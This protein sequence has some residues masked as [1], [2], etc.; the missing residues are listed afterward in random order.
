MFQGNSQT[1]RAQQAEHISNDNYGDVS[2]PFSPGSP[3][4]YVPQ[5]PMEPA[6]SRSEDASRASPSEFKSEVAGWPTQPRLVPTKI[7]CEL[8]FLM[9]CTQVS[10]D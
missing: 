9:H 2:L 1:K 5:M 3:L 7:L 8:F 6:L 10:L 4:T